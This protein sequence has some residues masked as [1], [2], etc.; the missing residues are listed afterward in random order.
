MGKLK[1]EEVLLRLEHGQGPLLIICH[2]SPDGDAIGASLAV[3][4]FCEC[5]GRS[6]VLVND[7]P[8][9]SRYDFL[10]YADQFRLTQD[11]KE[12]FSQAIAVDC[13]D[14]RRMGTTIA[15]LAD[16]AEL[17]N[18]DH[19]DTNDEFGQYAV[20]EPEAAAT[21][22]VLY[23]M[24]RAT[25]VPIGRAMALCLYTGIV[26]DTGGFRY[27]NS[28]PEIHMA[29]ADLLSRDIEPFLVADRVLEAM[30]REQVELIR[31]GLATLTV[32]DSGRIAHVVVDKHMLLAS[33]A[34]ESDSDVLLPFTRS[35]SGVE[36]GM[37]FREKPDGSV[38]VSMRSRDRVDVA[39]IALSFGGGGH[40]RA[41]GCNMEGPLSSAIESLLQRVREDV[42]V[43]FTE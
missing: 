8:V 12:Q 43:A 13:A 19:H 15:L 5:V 10:P 41:A 21:C 3:A 26:F 29:A 28:T 37:L 35:L 23:R 30:T 4:H 38:K 36:V 32:D 42:Q 18:V 7:D 25:G 6:F 33:G 27:N 40:V 22:L 11:V 34:N 14:Q 1:Y 20:V 31:L 17:I 24:M 2:I 39:A 16:Q 9:P